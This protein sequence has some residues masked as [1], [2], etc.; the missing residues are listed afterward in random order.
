MSGQ[1]G[2]ENSGAMDL[3][4]IPYE[5]NELISKIGAGLSQ[6]ELIFLI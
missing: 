3:T 1:L 6:L 2:S 5:R 4:L